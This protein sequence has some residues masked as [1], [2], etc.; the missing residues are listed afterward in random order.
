MPVVLIPVQ[1]NEMKPVSNVNGT[2]IHSIVLRPFITRDFMTGKNA[3]P[4]RDIPEKV[5]YPFR[6]VISL[7]LQTIEMI[8]NR[9]MSEVTYISRVLID[10]TSK[11]PGTTEWE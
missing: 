3:L 9:I 11:P 5:G 8:V 2:L 4:G 7:H 6:Q 10:L 1:F